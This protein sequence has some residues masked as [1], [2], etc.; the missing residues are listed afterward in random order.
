V[1]RVYVDMVADL[2]HY[3]HVE[4]LR[5]AR[6]LGDMLIVGIH[7][8]ATVQE[9]KRAPVMTM[10]ERVRVV[11]ACR[12]V[13]EVIPDAPLSVT[14]EWLGRHRIDL[15]VHGDD[16]D[17]DETT[18]MYEVPAAMGILRTVPYTSGISTSEVL[19]RLEGRLSEPD[20]GKRRGAP[21]GPAS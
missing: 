8:D 14:R 15:V 13:D 1:T 18:S 4:F 10:L 3:G 21:T 20:P 11:E 6:E 19:R 7:S 9:Y 12:Y 17:P 2:F 16:L 5:R